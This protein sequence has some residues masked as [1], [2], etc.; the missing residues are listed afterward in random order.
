MDG[1]LYPVMR[2]SVRFSWDKKDEER[3]RYCERKH[4]T[5]AFL[6]CRKV[7]SAREMLKSLC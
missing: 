1:F 7:F 6:H 3:L 2:K 4:S 5:S